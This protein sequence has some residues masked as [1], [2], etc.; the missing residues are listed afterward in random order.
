M[1]HR[2]IVRWNLFWIIGHTVFL[3]L[4]C[5][6]LLM[7]L[8]LSYN[9]ASAGS[10]GATRGIVWESYKLPITLVGLVSLIPAAIAAGITLSKVSELS[11]RTVFIG[12][13]P[14]GVLVAEAT[15]YFLLEAS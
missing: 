6:G 9:A 8:F 3:L 5:S 11:M 12:L 10:D 1:L 13:L 15:A 7:A 4:A 14:W 2:L